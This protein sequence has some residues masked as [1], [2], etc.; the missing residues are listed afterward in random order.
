MALGFFQLA[1]AKD[2]APLADTAFDGGILSAESLGRG[3][4]YVANP[5]TPAWASE[6]PAAMASL[7]RGGLYTTVRVGRSSD[8]PESLI[9]NL[10]PLRGRVMQFLAFPS[11]K[12]S[13]TFEPLG[14]RD[15]ID[16]L[17]STSPTTDFRNVDFAC[18]AIGFAGAQGYRHMQFGL[19]LSYLRASL[20][21]TTHRSG[22]PDQSQL[23]T[24]DGVRLNLGFQIPTGPVRW[25]LVLQ[26]A[27]GFLWWKDYRRQV[28]PLRVRIGNSWQV[29]KGT[30]L[31]I[32]AEQRYYR[33]GSNKRN[34]THIGYETKSWKK[35]SYRV[36]TFG[37]HIDKSDE[38][39]YT[40]GI[41]FET[42]NH[43]L[44]TYAA[45]RFRLNDVK[46]TES[47]LSVLVP[48]SVEDEPDAK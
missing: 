17:I 31:T 47:Y 1:Q 16:V 12:G 14:R 32:E 25:G 41:T 10:N 48:F 36:G 2:R 28:L 26:N 44:L 3:G 38:R 45:E 4:T 8:L 35:I 5:G 24:A 19:S 39:H 23:D 42:T 33:E 30:Y 6:N 27:P 20:A 34:F 7:P 9:N 18:D 46:V 40:A 11:D 21:S 29:Y 22:S 13:L 37:E 15:G 43:V